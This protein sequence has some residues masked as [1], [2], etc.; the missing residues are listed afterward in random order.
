MNRKILRKDG[1][2]DIVSFASPHL[3]DRK[4]RVA[5][6]QTSRVGFCTIV[7][8]APSCGVC[9]MACMKRLWGPLSLVALISISRDG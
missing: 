3:Y 2:Q 7:N 5:G 9:K 1:L 4:N 8:L 6:E